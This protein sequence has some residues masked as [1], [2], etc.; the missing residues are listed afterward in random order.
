MYKPIE[1]FRNKLAAGHLCLGAGITLA[2]AAVTEALGGSVDFFWIDLEHTTMT[3]ESLQTHLIAARAVGVPALVRV[4]GV[5]AWFIKRVLDAGA[6]GLIAPQVRSCEEVRLVVDACRYPP[7]GHR[8]Y[9][10][11][12][13]SNYGR[14][15]AMYRETI[16]QTL[17]VAAQIE[18]IEALRELDQIVAVPGLDSLVIGPYDLSASMGLMGQVTHPHLLAAIQ[19]IINAAHDHGLFVGMGGPADEEYAVRA[20]HMGVQWLQC[21][22]D[23]G[24]MLQFIHDFFPRLSARCQG[25][26]WVRNAGSGL[27][28]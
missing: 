27:K 16:N 28:Q 18:T 25:Q 8:G 19:R 7:K 4:P 11:R 14:D 5:E 20:A 12:R 13:A 2:D 15:E 22:S 9:G 10:P 6:Q 23:F 26:T 3:L 21:G 1:T 24:Y 17:F